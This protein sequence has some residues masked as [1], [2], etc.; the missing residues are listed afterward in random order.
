MAE[1]QVTVIA[2]IKARPGQEDRVRQELL[3]LLAPTR[4]EKGCVNFDMHQ[5]L[6]DPGL[7]LFHENWTSERDLDAHLQSPHIQRWITVSRDLLAE[8]IEITRLKRVG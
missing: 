5:A 8:P 1:S 3:A 7:F 2:C 6:N 4:V